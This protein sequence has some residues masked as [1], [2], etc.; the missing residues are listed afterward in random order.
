MIK[1]EHVFPPIPTRSH[2]WCAYLDGQ[3]EF[4]P[5]GW[6]PTEAAAIADQQMVLEDDERCPHCGKPNDTAVCIWGG[7]PIGADL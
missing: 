5:Q 7:C 2:D 3:E 4:G 1:T 6:G